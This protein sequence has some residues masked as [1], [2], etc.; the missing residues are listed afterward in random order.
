[1]KKLISLLMCGA[2]CI[3]AS[4]CSTKT[5]EEPVYPDSYTPFRFAAYMTPPTPNALNY[6]NPNYITDLRY[7]E[8]AEC[9]FD[10]GYAIYESVPEHIKAALGYAEKNNIKYYVKDNEITWF[11]T[12]ASQKELPESLKTH[13]KETMDEY[14]PYKSFAGIIAAD[15]ISK[16]CFGNAKLVKEYW[17]SLYPDKEFF[18]N[19]L[20]MVASPS[21]LGT[22]DYQDHLDSYIAA[23]KTEMLSYDYYP[24]IG[25]QD[26]E[27]V[28][29]AQH[30]RNLEIAVNT[31][32]KNKIPLYTFILTMGHMNYRTPDNYDDIAW[33]IYS[34]MAYGAKG[35]QTFTYWTT[36]DK[37][38][39]TITHGLID[40]EG[41][42]TPVYDAMKEV[43]AEVRAMEKYYMQFEYQGTIPYAGNP[44]LVQNQM[45]I[46]ETPL[47][48]HEA[49]SG[50]SAENDML[51]GA[52]ADK[53]GRD[54]FMVTNYCDPCLDKEN[55]IELTF[56]DASAVLTIYKGK[57]QMTDLKKGKY[58]FTL[59]SGEGIFIIPVK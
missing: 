42:R 18:I 10:Y 46:L 33:Q 29:G 16:S 17:D 52:F 1:M 55:K 7:A 44:D 8:M 3:G 54:G 12:G 11:I 50:F 2:I 25:A 43:I 5:A 13:I 45:S 26:N 21:Q 51:I 27:K 23:T 9:G 56:K 39:N 32:K 36:M 38:D 57:K 53:D 6:G 37:T 58:S 59:K 35:A 15:E 30:L 14:V 19:L 41:N 31:A 47:K 48:S 49:L 22:R 4:A 24:L 20:P 28:L 34:S 40:Q